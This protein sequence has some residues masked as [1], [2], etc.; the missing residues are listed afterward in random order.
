VLGGGSCDAL[1]SMFWNFGEEMRFLQGRQASAEYS[2]KWVQEW[3]RNRIVWEPSGSPIP[4]KDQVG[5]P[6]S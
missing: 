6:V 3:E 2:R 5:W 4:S 1:F